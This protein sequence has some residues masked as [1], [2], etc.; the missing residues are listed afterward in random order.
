MLAVIFALVALCA[1]SCVTFA[2]VV[3]VVRRVIPVLEYAERTLAIAS[4]AAAGGLATGTQIPRFVARRGDGSVLSDDDLRQGILLFLSAGC[5]PCIA[6]AREIAQSSRATELDDV[7]VLLST[8]DEREQLRLP[9]TVHVAYQTGR[10]VA[11]AFGT[12][13]TPHAFA[14]VDGVIRGKSTPSSLDALRA[15]HEAITEGGNRDKTIAQ[16]SAV[17]GPRPSRE[18][19]RLMGGQ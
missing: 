10:A 18:P 7:V 8:V 12:T 3:G 5:A 14:I 11:D 16:P 4:A 2:V 6:L 1:L 13:T 19:L 9:D 15:L 17:S